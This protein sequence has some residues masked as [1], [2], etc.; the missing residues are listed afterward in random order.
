MHLKRPLN[1]KLNNLF[2]LCLFV[3][4]FTVFFTWLRVAD[5]LPFICHFDW[6]FVDDKKMNL[7]QFF[8]AKSDLN[9]FLI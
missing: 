8:A 5:H 3:S 1:V 7:L 4:L 9:I 2:N 6:Y